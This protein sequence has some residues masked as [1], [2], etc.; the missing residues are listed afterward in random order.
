M[1]LHTST[2]IHHQYIHW[3][4]LL[5]EKWQEMLKLFEPTSD[6]NMLEQVNHNNKK[7]KKNYLP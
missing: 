4:D 3:N 7:L 1:T 2:W 5:P 6:C